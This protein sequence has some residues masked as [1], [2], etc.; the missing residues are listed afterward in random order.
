MECP[1]DHLQASAE[2]IKI[3]E[4]AE[5]DGYDGVISWCGGDARAQ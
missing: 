2:V 3:V 1:V 5:Q 4:K